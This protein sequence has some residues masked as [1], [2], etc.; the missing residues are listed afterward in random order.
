MKVFPFASNRAQLSERP[1][2][3]LQKKFSRFIFCG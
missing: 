3:I 2:F 1:V